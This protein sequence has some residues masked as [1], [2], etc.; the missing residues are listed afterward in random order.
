MHY[1]S[2]E[3]MADFAKSVEQKFAER[4]IRILDVGSMNVNGVYRELFRWKNADYVG[5]DIAYGPNVDI[6]LNDAYDWCELEDDSFD[7]IISGQA[8]EHIEFPWLILEQIARKLKPGG[9]VC[10]IAPSRGPE[11]RYPVDCYRYYPDG[12]DALAKWAGLDVIESDYVQE[13][14][15]F[16]DTSVEWGD[17]TCI[18]ANLIAPTTEVTR[19]PDN[20]PK[21]SRLHQL[22]SATFPALP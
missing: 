7:V 19:F 12:L 10:L 13:G 6:V 5:L 11:H 8:L 4:A 1:S 9:I 15:I 17:C 22:P 16:P 21:G 3:R 2:F 14:R 18:L 20:S